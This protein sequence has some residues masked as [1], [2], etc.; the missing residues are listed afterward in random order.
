MEQGVDTCD[1]DEKEGDRQKTL[2][3]ISTWR[4]GDAQGTPRE[5][6]L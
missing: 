3:A 2:R 6:I 5:D 1:S 4:V